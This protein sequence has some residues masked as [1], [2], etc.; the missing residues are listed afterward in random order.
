[1]P[2]HCV[3][4]LN[5]KSKVAWPAALEDQ[6]LDFARWQVSLV[7]HGVTWR[8]RDVSSDSIVRPLMERPGH[9]N[10]TMPTR[11]AT[12]HGPCMSWLCVAE[13]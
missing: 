4:A 10:C 12:W 3:A 2:A 7:S 5:A 9:S 13:G 8:R 1:M 6:G 11:T